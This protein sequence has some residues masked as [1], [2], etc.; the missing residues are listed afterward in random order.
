MNVV[1]GM[2]GILGVQRRGGGESLGSWG[3]PPPP[4]FRPVQDQISGAA[5]WCDFRGQ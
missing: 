4:N 1:G 3:I 2:E 5:K